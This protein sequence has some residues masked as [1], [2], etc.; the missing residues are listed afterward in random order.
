MICAYIN[1]KIAYPVSDSGIKITLQN[2]FI[3]DGDEKTMEVVFPLDIPENREVFGALNRIDTSFLCEDLEECIL[4]AD[5][6]VVVSGKGTITS[7]TEKEVKIQILAGKSYLKYKAS[8]DKIFIDQLDYGQV[9]DKYK[10]FA[11]AKSIQDVTKLDVLSDIRARGFIGEA[12]KYMFMPI[13]DEGNDVWANAP[14]YIYTPGRDG[15]LLA[16]TIVQAAVQPNLM[17][18]FKK[19]MDVLGYQII[20]NDFDSSPWNK[21]YIASARVSLSLAKALPHW[22]CYKFIDEMRKLFNAVFVFDETKKTVSIVPFEQASDNGSVEIEPVEEFNTSYDEQGIEYLEASNIQYEISGC[23]RTADVITEEIMNMFEVREYESVDVMRREYST[24]SVK[25]KLTTLFHCPSGWFYGYSIEVGNSMAYYMK[26]CGWFSP[27]IRRQGASFV[28]LNI[29]PVAMAKTE[30]R[31]CMCVRAMSPILAIAGWYGNYPNM[32]LSFEGPIANCNC[33]T[34]TEAEYLGTSNVREV[35]YVTVQD[36]LE[37]GESVP[38]DESDNTIMEVFF[39]EGKTYRYRG[40]LEFVERL[41][42]E[43]DMPDPPSEIILPIPF[44]DGRLGIYDNIQMPAYSMALTPT[45]NVTAIAQYHNK[46]LKIRRNI[47]GNNEI[48]FK[49]IYDGK[50]DP[51]K[52]YI[53]RGKRFICSRIEMAINANGLDPMKTG[54]FYEIL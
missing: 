19:V 10:R 46:G 34:Q 33:E 3:K 48:C 18:V 28:S 43:M 45:S 8:F 41:E 12:G 49:F 30:A 44:T 6:F 26:E 22:S 40:E 38:D 20:R 9:S 7:I 36:V 23:E 37:N 25:D 51:R 13:H 14:G 21:L 52:I 16:T 11:T 17:M 1:G 29:V 4:M 27:L 42:M 53:C 50:P 31:I 15:S 47:N 32:V 24:L 35:E 5:N 39:V 2:P 54:Y